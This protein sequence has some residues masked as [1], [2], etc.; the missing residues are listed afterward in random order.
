MTITFSSL[1]LKP[2]DL[3]FQYQNIRTGLQTVQKLVIKYRQ[4]CY[5][6]LYTESLGQ[7]NIVAMT[8]MNENQREY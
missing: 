5:S 8:S 1:N 3:L 4:A 7:V 2:Y 6:G